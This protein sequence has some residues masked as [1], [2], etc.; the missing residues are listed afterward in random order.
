MATTDT[1]TAKPKPADTFQLPDTPRR[2]SDE[3]T[4]FDSLHSLG[5]SHHII[6]H[7][8]NEKTTLVFTDKYISLNPA[9]GP[10]DIRRNPDLAVALN[11]DREAFL[12]RNGYII[13]EQGKAPDFALEIASRS[14]AHVDVG[15]KRVDY[16]VMGITE[17]WRF[18]ET[19]EYYGAT[20]AGDRLVEGRYEPIPIVELAEGVLE[21]YIEVLDLNIRWEHGHLGW[22][23][24]A[25]GQHIPTFDSERE[26]ADGERERA[27]AAEA[28]VLE[29]EAEI[30]RL[31]ES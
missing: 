11:A 21:G 9:L 14:T 7:L 30:R 29:L 10:E 24:P 27:A 22:Y 13:S 15:Q 25:T 6:R 4:S 18:D 3:M 5:N 19:G 23:D 17:Y 16:A 28:R 2:E 8:G 26:R 31:R 20:L 1:L 12:R